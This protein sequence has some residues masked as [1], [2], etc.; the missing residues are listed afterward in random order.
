MVILNQTATKLRACILFLLMLVSSSVLSDIAQLK[1]ADKEQ[2]NTLVLAVPERVKEHFNESGPYVMRLR[3]AFTALGYQ[4]NFAFYPGV[5]SLIMSNT[6]QVDGELIREVNI[7]KKY[8]NLRP[9]SLH[10]T[11]HPALYGRKDNTLPSGKTPALKTV[12]ITRGGVLSAVDIPVDMKTLKIVKISGIQQGINLV[13]SGRV[14]SLLMSQELFNYLAT[15]QPIL[16]TQLVKLSPAIAPLNLYT[17]LHKKH[18]H[19]IPDVQEQ[20]RIQAL[21]NDSYNT[22]N[23]ANKP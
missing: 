11:I 10:I 18:E 22:P 8:T 13:I 7:D 4:V 23:S 17:Y 21:E 16:T 5:R 19:L 2:S 3:K 14:D 15:L 12:A 9:L 6:G 1:P 20:L